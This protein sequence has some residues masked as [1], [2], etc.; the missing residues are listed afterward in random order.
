MNDDKFYV[1]DKGVWFI[2]ANEKKEEAAHSPIW[3]CSPLHVK[4]IT[5]DNDNENQGRLLVFFDSENIKHQWAMPM[6]LTATDG[7]E[8]RKNLLS[9]GLIIGPKRSQKD[10]LNTYISVTIPQTKMRCIDKTGWFE[11]SF[12][13]PHETIGMGTEEEIIYQSVNSQIDCYE[14][15]GTLEDWQKNV[16][17]FCVDNSRLAFSVCEAFA[18]PLLYWLDEESGGFHY[19]GQSSKGKSTALKT[20]ASVYGGKKMINSWRA[21]INGLEAMAALHNDSL[22]ILDEMSQV[23]PKEAGNA[24]Y[25]LAN[26]CGKARANKQGFARKKHEWRLL[27]LSSGEVSLADHMKQSGKKALAG[28]EIRILNIPAI[29]GPHGVFEYLHNSK[30]GAIF[31]RMLVKNAETYFGVAGKA[32]IKKL[33]EHTQDYIVRLKELQQSFN[34]EHIPL[35]A[36]GQVHRALYR[37]ALI[38]AAGTLATEIGITDWPE[39]EAFW[40]VEQCFKAWIKDRGGV[41]SQEEKTSLAKVRHFFELHGDSRFAPWQSE[42]GNKTINRAGYKR[43]AEDTFHYYVFTEVFKDDICEGLNPELVAQLCIKKGWLIPDS[44]GKS[45]RAENLPN[46]KNSVRCYRFDGSKIFA[47]IIE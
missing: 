12:I 29:V 18:A 15:A 28:Q 31:S 40:A 33:T 16:S 22:L 7:T 46:C 20:G 4:A 6:A 23:D 38:A 35:S 42:Q 21:T 3:I 8:L 26:N 19:V 41:S 37:F 14:C 17:I 27:F 9:M 11:N 36:D 45:T 24:A 13:L 43:L 44:E 25:L 10:L 30:N 5:R 32:F 2:P 1:D 39:E 34:E 47:D